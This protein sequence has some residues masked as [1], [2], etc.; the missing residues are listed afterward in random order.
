M[1]S[2]ITLNLGGVPRVS[3]GIQK[4]EG[5]FVSESASYKVASGNRLTMEETAGKRDAARKLIDAGR[6]LGKMLTI[7]K[8]AKAK[9]TPFT[10]KQKQNVSLA[11]ARATATRSTI[12]MLKAKLGL[13]GF[14]YLG[15]MKFERVKGSK[16]IP[17]GVYTLKLVKSKKA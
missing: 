11:R 1:S 14:K 8:K 16:T 6:Y 7:L 4:K 12:R 10:S 9:T 2:P 13:S 15:G 17:A 5:T 3:T